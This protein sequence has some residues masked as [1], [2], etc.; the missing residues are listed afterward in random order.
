MI[1]KGLL[2]HIGLV[3]ISLVMIFTFV[4]PRFDAIG[5]AQSKIGTYKEELQK[6]SS[7]NNKLSQ[8]VASIENIP[9]T[10]RDRLLRYMPDTVDTIAVPRDIKVIADTVGVILKDIKY[11]GIEKVGRADESSVDKPEI[12]IFSLSFESSYD[13]IKTVIDTLERNAYPLEIHELSIN[14]IEGGFLAVSMKV[15]TYGIVPTLE[16]TTP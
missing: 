6:V 5:A 15:Y 11:E 9:S 10:D 12:H 8:L 3:G 4:K 13:Q 1:P 2:T 7:V 16:I 14:K